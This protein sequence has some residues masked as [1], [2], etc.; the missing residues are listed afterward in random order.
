VWHPSKQAALSVAVLVL[1]YILQQRFQP[2]VSTESIAESLNLTPASIDSRMQGAVGA[3]A[4]SST[5]GH[6]ARAYA[7]AGGRSQAKPR[8][9]VYRAGLSAKE[10]LRTLASSALRV[11]T[12]KV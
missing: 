10:R 8:G 9:S 1:S 7:R 3:S 5:S 12:Y 2:F 6:G 11:V 4:G